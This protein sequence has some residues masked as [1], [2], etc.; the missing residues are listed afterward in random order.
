MIYQQLFDRISDKK[1]V[2]FALI[3]AGHYGKELVAQG[4][5]NPL[6]NVPAVSDVQL[7][8]AREAFLLEG[9]AE[10][11]IVACDSRKIINISSYLYL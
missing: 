11:D 9:V 10:D 7:Q 3:G 1:P 6:L 8:L 2:S 4:M 5:R